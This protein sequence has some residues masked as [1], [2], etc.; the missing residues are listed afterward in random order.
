MRIEFPKPGFLSYNVTP[1]VQGSPDPV[2]ITQWELSWGTNTD[3]LTTLLLLWVRKSFISEPLQKKFFISYLLPAS[4]ANLLSCKTCQSS[5]HL[6]SFKVHPHKTGINQKEETNRCQLYQMIHVN[7]IASWYD[8]L[9]AIH[10]TVIFLSTR[11]L[12][13]PNWGPFLKN[14]IKRKSKCEW[15]KMLT[16]K[17]FRLEIHKNPLYYFLTFL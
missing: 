13:N 2:H 4:M 15:G 3:I 17:E 7:I 14:N 9:T 10:F 1:F 6:H 12:T 16:F 8:E 11:R 5:W